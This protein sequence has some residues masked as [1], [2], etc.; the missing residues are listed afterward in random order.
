[1]QTFISCRRKI[2]MNYDKG[3]LIFLIAGLVTSLAYMN[4]SL[5]AA[6]GSIDKDGVKGDSESYSFVRKWGSE[7]TGDG[8]L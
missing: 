4:A 5:P 8:Q 3:Y 1:M 2:D 6:S 7:G